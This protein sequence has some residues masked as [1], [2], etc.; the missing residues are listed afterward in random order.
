MIAETTL[1]E[2][3]II[4]LFK[5]DLSCEMFGLNSFVVVVIVNLTIF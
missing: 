1:A 5:Y 2:L 3:S 4:N